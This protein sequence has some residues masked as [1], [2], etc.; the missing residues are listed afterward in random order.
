M[1]R[2]QWACQSR[3]GASS[4]PVA[5]PPALACYG[6]LV[7]SHFLAQDGTACWRLSFFW[8]YTVGP[9]R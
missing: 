5:I 3:L 9:P 7:H 2:V 6:Y 1:D 8:T 4:R